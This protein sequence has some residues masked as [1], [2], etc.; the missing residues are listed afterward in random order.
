MKRLAIFLIL[1][2]FIPTLALADGEGADV[3]STDRVIIEDGEEADNVVVLFNDAYIYGRVHD[4]V[5]V[6]M[7]DADMSE[8]A[9]VDGRLMVIGGDIIA[10]DDF[11]TGRGIYHINLKDEGLNEFLLSVLGFA[12]LEFAKLFLICLLMAASVIVGLAFPGWTGRASDK[13][14]NAG[15]AVGLGIVLFLILVTAVLILVFTV[16]GIPVAVF[17][18]VLTATLMVLGFSV[19]SLT[20]GR[21]ILERMGYEAGG[22]AVPLVGTVILSALSGIPIIGVILLVVF[23]IAGMGAIAENLMRI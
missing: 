6:I 22:F 10:P 5:F 18:T 2:L 12:G 21:A 20:V 14:L 11:K 7:G 13:L 17:L 19:A 9:K 3:V 8:N 4:S 1:L 15:R 23:S 16:V